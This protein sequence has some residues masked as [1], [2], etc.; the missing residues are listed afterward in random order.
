MPA[1]VLKFDPEDRAAYCQKTWGVTPDR[2]WLRIKYWTDDLSQT[3]NTIFSNGDLDPWGPGGVLSDIRAD[4]P[5]P[6]VHGGAHNLDLRG[7]NKGDPKSV[8]L[9]RDFHME[10]ID[11]WIKDYQSQNTL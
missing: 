7:S 1:S 2:D 11:Q 4:L 10:T 3:S 9:V 8:L 6:V 5:A